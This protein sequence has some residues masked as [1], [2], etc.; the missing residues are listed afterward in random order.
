ML[1]Y[2]SS[3]PRGTIVVDNTLDF[4]SVLFEEYGTNLRSWPS[5]R[6]GVVAPGLRK[7]VEESSPELASDPEPT[8]A[9]EVIVFDSPTEALGPMVVTID[10]SSSSGGRIPISIYIH[11]SFAFFPL[12]FCFCM[13][14]Y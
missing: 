6:E 3:R 5:L 8:P 2:E 12:C 11:L 7:Y 13:T 4:R 10:S 14:V 9:R 1:D